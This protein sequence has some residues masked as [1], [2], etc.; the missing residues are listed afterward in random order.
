[1]S[2]AQNSDSKHL[3]TVSEAAAYL[4]LSR[5]SV[6]KLAE[7]RELDH[8]KVGARLLFSTEQLDAWLTSKLVAAE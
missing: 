7:R 5:S 4:R 6:Y 1:M 3:H 8:F 2:E